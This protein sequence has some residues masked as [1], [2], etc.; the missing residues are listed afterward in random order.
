MD[1][2]HCC[3]WRHVPSLLHYFDPCIHP[4]AAE[5]ISLHTRFI[6]LHLQKALEIKILFLP[7]SVKFKKKIKNKQINKS[8][9]KAVLGK[10]GNFE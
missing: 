2:P 5:Y 6:H 3:T 1:E 8:Q 7:M 9:T 4:S 10:Y